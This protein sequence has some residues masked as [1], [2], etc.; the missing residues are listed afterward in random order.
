M[1][2]G[3]LF[4]DVD[5]T[6]IDSKKGKTVPDKEVIEAI[7][8]VRQN[9]YYCMISSGR[10]M[11][12]LDAF[13]NSCF[14]GFVFSD[15]AGIKMAG[16]LSEVIP[17]EHDDVERILKELVNDYACDV[18]ACWED[19]SF[20]SQSTYKRIYELYEE[21]IEEA[22][23]QKVLSEQNIALLDIWKDE[24]ILEVDI[25][26]PDVQTKK[27]WMDQ[28]PEFVE[29]VDMEGNYGEITMKGV[30]KASGCVRIA[31]KLGIEMN[32]CYAFGDSMNDKEM[33]MACGKSVLM[34][35][36]DQRLKD[37][38]DYVTGEVDDGGLIQGFRY[39]G[40]I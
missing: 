23:I 17:F 36:G 24:L 6:L 14:D 4:F 8:K 11:A 1:K 15:G 28:K 31:K 27:K 25:F 37:F 38:V 9:G 30:S 29:F 13:L 40:L 39:F 26:F 12:G 5:G 18:N 2:K 20:V 35:N 34:G 10:N 33:L 7:Q 22:E 32:D 3:I 19:G 16:Q 21:N